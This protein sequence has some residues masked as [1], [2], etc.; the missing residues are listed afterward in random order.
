MGRSEIAELA[1]MV[2]LAAVIWAAGAVYIKAMD[3]W[4][5]R[6]APAGRT[7]PLRPARSE[8]EAQIAR[9][10]RRKS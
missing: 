3:Y 2:S 5:Q 9:R 4:L 6:R 10:P 1:V 8:A 7:P